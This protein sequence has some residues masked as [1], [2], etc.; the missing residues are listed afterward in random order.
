VTGAGFVTA[1]YRDA[2][3]SACPSTEF[4][5]VHFGVPHAGMD[6]NN[7]ASPQ[8]IHPDYRGPRYTMTP[9]TLV[10]ENGN[11]DNFFNGFGWGAVG[12]VPFGIHY[13]ASELLTVTGPQNCFTAG[14]SASVS[15]AFSRPTTANASEYCNLADP[16][17]LVFY[18]PV[19][20]PNELAPTLTVK[21]QTPGDTSGCQDH[22][23]A[24]YV[25]SVY[26]DTL[27]GSRLP[28]Y[29]R[30]LGVIGKPGYYFP[31]SRYTLRSLPPSQRTANGLRCL[32]LLTTS[33]VHPLDFN[34][35]DESE[36]FRI[37]VSCFTLPCVGR[38]IDPEDP[39]YCPD[40]ELP[41]AF[42]DSI[43]F[44]N[45]NSFFDP[46]DVDAFLSVFSE[47]PCIPATAVCNDVDF[48][49]DG[50]LFDP[51]DVD[52]FFMVFS[53]GPCTLCGT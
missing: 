37:D 42:C 9:G 41:P 47:G 11:P 31:G 36:W 40:D 35:N 6:F 53:E 17:D 34:E 50:S 48:N 43:D 16:V 27:A 12:L 26:Q 44:N 23:D 14:H 10:H 28:D 38:A 25:T 46:T 39:N 3:R 8:Y 33:V 49:N 20:R 5:C 7:P 51:C 4:G 52:A 32:D 30:R 19:G 15:R 21:L 24:T 29:V 1:E 18:G 13:A 22:A 45:D 2:W